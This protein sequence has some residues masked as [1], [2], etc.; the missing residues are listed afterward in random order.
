MDARRFLGRDA[1]KRIE[2]KQDNAV[3]RPSSELRVSNCTQARRSMRGAGYYCNWKSF[4]VNIKHRKF[5][6]G[7]FH[8]ERGG[9]MRSAGTG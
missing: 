9:D 2:N 1:A 3:L 4:R 5:Q 8:T 6:G 7:I